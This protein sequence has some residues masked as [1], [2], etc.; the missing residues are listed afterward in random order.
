VST[1]TAAATGAAVV[2][3]AGGALVA[4][5]LGQRPRVAD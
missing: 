1:G 3:V 2:A 4:W 5:R